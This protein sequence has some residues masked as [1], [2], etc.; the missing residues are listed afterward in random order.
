VQIAHCSDHGVGRIAM[1][2]EGV[3]EG[4][5]THMPQPHGSGQ[6]DA[7]DRPKVGTKVGSEVYRAANAVW[8]NIV[9]LNVGRLLKALENG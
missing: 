6:L 3:S 9:E 2:Y 1:K 8:A 4:H 5:R 7:A